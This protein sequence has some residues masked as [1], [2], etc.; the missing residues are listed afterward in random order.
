MEPSEAARNALE[1]VFEAKAGE[2]I[3]ITC[4]D[5]KADIGRAFK[6]GAKTLGLN[7]TLLLLKTDPKETRTEIPA[8]VMPYLTAKRPDIYINLL[9]GNRE[10]T[11][12][13]IKL[14]H[15]QMEPPKRRLGHCPG[16]SLD[17]LTNGALALTVEEHRQ[18]QQFAKALIKKLKT[19]VKIQIT[20]PKGTDLAFSVKGRVF[21]TDTRVDW[22]TLKWMNLPTGEVIVAPVEDSLEGTL[23]CDVAIGGIGLVKAPVTLKVKG[24]KVDAATCKDKEVLRRVQDSLHTDAMAKVVGE[25]AFGINPKA[26]VIEEFLE[27]EKI[28]GTVHIAFGDNTDFPGGKNDSAN[29]MD[30]LMDKPTVKAVARNG[31]ITLMLEDGVF[32]EDASEEKLP[33]SDFYKVVSYVTIFKSADWWE[34]AVAFEVYGKRQLGLYLWQKRGGE[35]KRK[36]KFGIRTLEEWEKIKTA[37][38]K[39]AANLASK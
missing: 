12:F 1:C 20:T 24:G 7:V 35:W 33:I 9:G 11:P 27:T 13:R 3:V 10:E 37:M 22:K 5:T 6:E 29:H 23:V 26:R 8:E 18:M 19:A 16:V 30:F 34:A 28:R 32:P 31:V 25:F 14:I 4:D 36:N 15:A 21:F 39:L 2:S 38:G 17:M